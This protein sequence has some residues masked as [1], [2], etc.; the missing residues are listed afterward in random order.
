MTKAKIYNRLFVFVIT[1]FSLC[2][3]CYNLFKF[4]G[5]ISHF[6]KDFRNESK[7]ISEQLAN[8]CLLISLPFYII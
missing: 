7:N 3:H 2:I 1:Y 5:K 8:M 6:L 4:F